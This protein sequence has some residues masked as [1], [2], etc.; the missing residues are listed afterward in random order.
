MNRLLIVAAIAQTIRAALVKN[1]DE[2]GRNPCTAKINCEAFLNS[3][4]RTAG[5]AVPSGM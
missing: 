4:I 5:E 2:E 3:E 1:I